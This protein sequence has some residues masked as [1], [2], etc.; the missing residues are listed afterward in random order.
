MWIV[1]QS[2]LQANRLNPGYSVVVSTQIITPDTPG[3][4]EEELNVYIEN[5][6]QKYGDAG[7]FGIEPAVSIKGQNPSNRKNIDH[8]RTWVDNLEYR[9]DNGVLLASSDNLVSLYK[10]DTTDE[11]GREHY[12]YWQWSAAQ[13]REDTLSNEDSNLRRIYNKVDFNA[14]AIAY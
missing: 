1:V 9:N 10:L 3:L 7:V 14:L 11:L 2:R 6:K 5:M 12:Y 8:V 4:S 13:N